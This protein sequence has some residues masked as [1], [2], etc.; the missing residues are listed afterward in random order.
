[1]PPITRASISV[2]VIKVNHKP[3][4]SSVIYSQAERCVWSE[5]SRQMCEIF[6]SHRSNFRQLQINRRSREPSRINF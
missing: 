3:R 6:T 4:A 1:M 2:V 5:K